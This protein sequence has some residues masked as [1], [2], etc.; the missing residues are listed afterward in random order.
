MYYEARIHEK[1]P[2]LDTKSAALAYRNS[3]ESY[4]TP[5]FTI[6]TKTYYLVP[7]G[8]IDNVKAECAVLV[9]YNGEFKQ[10]ESITSAWVNSD[11]KFIEYINKAIV[12]PQK[13]GK[14]NIVFDKPLG[15]EMATFECGCCG[16][17]FKGN[18][19]EQLEYDQD[20]GYGICIS[21]SHWY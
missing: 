4:Q 20:A 21:C 17:Q 19:Q 11:E 14:A 3:S 9:E 1:L 10:I 2:M 8:H 6:D 12:N 16:N 7:D 13:M 15:H 18:I 5:C